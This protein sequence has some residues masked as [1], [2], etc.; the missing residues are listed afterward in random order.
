MPLI[1]CEVVART[2][3]AE[4]GTW[5]DPWIDV[6]SQPDLFV[7]DGDRFRVDSSRSNYFCDAS[8]LVEKPRRS[9][10]IFVLGGSTVQGRPFA[11]ETAFPRWLELAWQTCGGSASDTGSQIEVINVG[12]VSYAS[13]RIEK[14]LH[15]VLGHQPDAIVLYT[16]HNEFLESRT[17]SHLRGRGYLA[18]WLDAAAAKLKT[19][20]WLQRALATPVPQQVL[21][22]EV[23]ASLDRKGGLGDYHRDEVWRKGVEEDFKSSLQRMVHSCKAAGVPVV[24]CVPASDAVRTP[25]FKTEADPRLDLQTR[26]RVQEDWNV[27]LGDGSA[28]RKREACRRILAIDPLHAGANFWMGKTSWEDRDRSPATCQKL[29]IARDHDVCPLRATTTIVQSVRKVA[30]EGAIPVVDVPRLFD[31]DA[32]GLEDPRWFVDHLHPSVAGHQK[33]AEALADV[34]ADF[35]WIRIDDSSRPLIRNAFD[36]YLGT[37]GED[38]FQRG[39]QRREGLQ[40]WAAGRAGQ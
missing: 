17:Y 13:Y 11:H 31:G 25:P 7:Q 8:F 39:R 21:G 24:I 37:L 5:S 20:G 34:L 22:A 30:T 4:Q 33:I 36:Q 18:R 9:R 15:E 3:M 27:V 26:E 19:V 10:R 2:W 16:G 40:Q 32:D 12:G 38:Y 6:S 1:A 35:G 14:L 23:T 28:E 29:G